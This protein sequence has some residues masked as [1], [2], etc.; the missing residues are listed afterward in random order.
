[1][2]DQASRYSL[3]AQDFQFWKRV[4]MFPEM[5]QWN[6]QIILFSPAINAQ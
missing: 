5:T 3:N 1:M 4:F 2:R 6:N